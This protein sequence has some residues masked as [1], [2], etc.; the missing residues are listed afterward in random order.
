M[1]YC[2]LNTIRDIQQSCLNYDYNNKALCVRHQRLSPPVFY[3]PRFPEE[4]L[5]Y[6]DQYCVGGFGAP[7]KMVEE[8]VRTWFGLLKT[9]N[10]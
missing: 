1:A 4:E 10:G 3:H 5:N 8:E 7:R 6:Y 2:M 9:N